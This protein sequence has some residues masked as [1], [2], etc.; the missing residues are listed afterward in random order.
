MVEN[1]SKVQ[2]IDL[3]LPSRENE[4]FIFFAEI[5]ITSLI[6]EDDVVIIKEQLLNRCFINSFKSEELIYCKENPINHRALCYQPF[7]YYEEPFKSK[8]QS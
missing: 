6:A 8:K 3:I 7:K 5:L 4:N 1:Y 2:K